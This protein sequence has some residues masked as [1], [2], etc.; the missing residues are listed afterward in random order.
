MTPKYIVGPKVKTGM[1]EGIHSLT[2]WTKNRLLLLMAS[3]KQHHTMR[4]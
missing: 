4:V 3:L 2:S 1:T